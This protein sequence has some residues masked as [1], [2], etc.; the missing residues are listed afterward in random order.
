MSCLRFLRSPGREVTLARA[1]R[2]RSWSEASV[3]KE[4]NGRAQRNERAAAHSRSVQKQA[5]VKRP[6]AIPA[7]VPDMW[8]VPVPVFPRTALQPLVRFF[9][10]SGKVDP[11][12]PRSADAGAATAANRA[13]A[14][15][16]AMRRRFMVTPSVSVT[17]TLDK[18]DPIPGPRDQQSLTLAEAR[19][20][21]RRSHCSLGRVQRPRHRVRHRVLRIC[22]ST[23]NPA[24]GS[25]SAPPWPSQ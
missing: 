15:A 17:S 7:A 2:R 5:S 9:G 6:P 18:A 21:L 10:C 25:P 4:R 20:E 14:A 11:G 3:Q 8:A 22:V 16:P 23:R 1:G 12:A 19:S 24:G 13:S